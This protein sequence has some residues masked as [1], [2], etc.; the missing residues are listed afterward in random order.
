MANTEKKES[1]KVIIGCCIT[2]FS[3]GLI[4]TWSLYVKPLSDLYGWE[5]NQ[6]TLA[7]SI[8]TMMIPIVM[9]FA[10]RVMQKIGPSKTAFIGAVLLFSGLVVCKF[11]TTIPMLYVGWGVLVGS[12]VGFI[13]GCP[14]PAATSWYPEKKGTISGLI[15]TTYGV[16]PIIFST[17]FTMLINK[18]GPNNMFL[19]H[20]VGVLVLL[21]IG[22]P[23]IK[24]APKKEHN[25]DG[26]KESINE[27]EKIHQFTPSEML[28]TS[29]FWLLILMY[30]IINMAGLG[31]IN[32]G[33]P[34]AQ[35]LGGLTPL[36][37]ATIVSFVSICNTSSRFIE[38]ALA[39]KIG[40]RNVLSLIFLTLT[41][42]PADI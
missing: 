25:I 33:S 3:T 31:V 42:L 10:S 37:A 18:V 24:M 28:K 16:G 19:I 4:Y 30:V 17:I 26:G 1:I 8:L 23:M 5:T 39:D 38:G 34:I 9:I 2:L 29:S 35:T 12:G 32:S 22:I 20:G 11:A 41:N 21:L 14:V 40:A 6:I 13:Y 27:I 36:Q 15:L 7:F